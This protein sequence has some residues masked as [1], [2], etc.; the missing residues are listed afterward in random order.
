AC[1]GRPASLRRVPLLVRDGRVIDA[2]L[3]ARPAARRGP[4]GPVPH[5]G[6]DGGTRPDRQRSVVRPESR[7]GSAGAPRPRV[8]GR[9]PPG[10]GRAPAAGDLPLT[11][12]P[13]DAESAPG[14]PPVDIPVGTPEEA[15]RALD[16]VVVGDDGLLTVP[17]VDA[18]RAERRAGPL[19]LR[20][21]GLQADALIL[22]RDVRPLVV[23]PAQQ[24]EFL[25]DLHRTASTGTATLPV[26]IWGALMRWFGAGG[27]S[28]SRAR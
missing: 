16:A 22:D 10:A 23:L 9:R 3:P 26:S 27:G 14:K 1:G 7:P 19:P 13:L 21:A 6:A 18:G 20:P 17:G 28:S 15:G 24:V 12:L 25:F 8:M 11:V 5:L 2:A 4:D